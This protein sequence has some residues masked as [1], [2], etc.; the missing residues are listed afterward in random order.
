MSLVACPNLFLYIFL[1][2]AC[3]RRLTYRKSFI[4]V[5]ESGDAPGRSDGRRGSGSRVRS[6]PERRSFTLG[7]DELDA[8]EKEM[9]GCFNGDL[10]Y[11]KKYDIV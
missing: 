5:E 10:K 2:S 1:P 6:V 3:L 7:G 9:A 8:R 11:D 4:D